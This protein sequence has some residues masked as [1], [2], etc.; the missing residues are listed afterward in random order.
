MHF[1]KK[2]LG[3]ETATCAGDWCPCQAT[4]HQ[5]FG[6]VLWTLHS[7]TQN[8]G[9]NC[10]A[11]S[12]VYVHMVNQR[13]SALPSKILVSFEN[14]DVRNMGCILRYWNISGIL[15]IDFF[16]PFVASFFCVLWPPVCSEPPV[17]RLNSHLKL[18]DNVSS[19][20]RSQKK[21]KPY[22]RTGKSYKILIVG[23]SAAL[24]RIVHSSTFQT[25]HHYT[26][27]SVT[28]SHHKQPPPHYLLCNQ[29][30]P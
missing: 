3:V 9:S 28:R 19:V 29:N 24:P 21:K 20:L 14:L 26:M 7:Y 17:W 30:P 22:S 11:T 2:R 6:R 18:F 15:Y 5:S 23:E 8:N 13:I 1:T 16:L 25:Q 10:L 27:C 12:A 4:D